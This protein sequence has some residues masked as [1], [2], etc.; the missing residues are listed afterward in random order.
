MELYAYLLH[1]PY[2]VFTFKFLFT[3]LRQDNKILGD[4][5]VRTLTNIGTETGFP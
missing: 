5:C 4:A 3:V 2:V 1:R